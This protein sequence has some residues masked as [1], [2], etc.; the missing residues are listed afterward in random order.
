MCGVGTGNEITLMPLF[1]LNYFHSQACDIQMQQRQ[2]WI[3][4]NSAANASRF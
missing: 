3:Q 2:S 1:S 4:K